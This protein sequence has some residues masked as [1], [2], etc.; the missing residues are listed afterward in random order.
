MTKNQS[1]SVTPEPIE[2]GRRL[3]EAREYLGLS[4]EQ[5]A[6][7]LRIPRP[8]VSQ[9]EAGKRGISFLEL[10]RLAAL[11]RRPLEYFSNDDIPAADDTA[12]ALFRTAQELSSDDREQVLRFAQFLRTAGPAKAPTRN[13][14]GA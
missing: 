13:S 2:L 1:E 5:V 3:R 8:S 6:D 14:T 4:Q 12:D 11:Y 9:F 10:K 7:H